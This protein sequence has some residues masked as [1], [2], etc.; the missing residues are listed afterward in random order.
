MTDCKDKCSKENIIYKATCNRCTEEQENKG[1]KNPIIPTYIGESSRTLKIRSKQHYKD[2]ERMKKLT[3]T[4][5]NNLNNQHTT[6][7]STQQQ[8]QQ[9]NN[10]SSKQQQQ[11]HNNISS[12]MYDH[13]NKNHSQ[14][15][16]PLD[17]KSDYSFQVIRNHR[18]AMS[19]QIEEAVRINQALDY[20][21]MTNRENQELA[22]I[23]LNRRGEHYPPRVR[24]NKDR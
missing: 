15:E 5:L 19:R 14:E 12:W 13:Y 21:T 3:P 1:I 4:E 17:P 24:F 22:I 11:Q 16:E 2:C 18:D 8:Q 20:G 9:H 10:I 7:T 6:T 23:S